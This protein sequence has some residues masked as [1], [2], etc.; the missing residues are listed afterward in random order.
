MNS[1]ANAN[2]TIV[3]SESIT[4][5]NKLQV[6]QIWTFIEL[7]IS[8]AVDNNTALLRIDKL[9]RSLITL[10][11]ENTS[12]TIRAD[13]TPITL[14]QTQRWFVP[15]PKCRLELMRVKERQMTMNAWGTVM[16][17]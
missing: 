8:R 4:M 15:T 1:I 6:Q 7:I 3:V 9:K 11:L 17:C 12:M 2:Q 10:E 13:G 5:L 16:R 14:E